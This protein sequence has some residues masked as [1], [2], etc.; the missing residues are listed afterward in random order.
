MS[1]NKYRDGVNVM[2]K[3]LKKILLPLIK[4]AQDEVDRTAVWCLYP[5][6]CNNA[7]AS[8]SQQKHQV[9]ESIAVGGKV[10]CT[11]NDLTKRFARFLTVDDLDIEIKPVE[12]ASAS[13]FNGFCNE[14]DTELFAPI[15]KSVLEKGN[16]D[17]LRAL[18]LRALSYEL[19][20]QRMTLDF[21]EKF[22]DKIS[23]AEIP[24]DC[25]SFVANIYDG[26]KEDIREKHF[27]LD[28]DI[29]HYWIPFWKANCTMSEYGWSWRTLPWNVGVSITSVFSPITEKQT[30][31]FFNGHGCL[32]PRP[33]T[34]FSVIPNANQTHI[35]MI[36][37]NSSTPFMERMVYDFESPAEHV[38]LRLLNEC[39]FTRS[40]DYCMSPALW[41][42][43]SKNEQQ[44]IRFATHHEYYRGE[45]SEVPQVI[46]RI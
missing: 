32:M 25:Q 33:I 28:S 22:I 31:R 11:S 7:I 14:H 6:C 35:V 34:T 38:F 43:L 17:Q 9:L 16:K 24:D 15:E 27:L 10:F 29:H 13:T 4:E 3:E 37:P 19:A 39:V 20:R 1:Y 41:N 40:E 21:R 2:T 26:Y 46:K 45:L 36:W 18:Y 8:H 44:A 12:I 23:C 42:G 30:A 5:G